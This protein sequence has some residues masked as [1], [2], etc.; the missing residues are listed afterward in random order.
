MQ[1]QHFKWFCWFC[2]CVGVLALGTALVLGT[3]DACAGVSSSC[4]HTYTCEST[5]G[6]GYRTCQNGC[7]Y[8]VE[9]SS[10][11]Y[12]TCTLSYERCVRTCQAF[13]GD[14]GVEGR[15]SPVQPPVSGVRP[16]KALESPPPEHPVSPIGGGPL[17]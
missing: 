15:P 10:K 4:A 14:V 9:T 2:A 17:R 6:D 12:D 7:P 1:W 5:C 8:K 16:T 3:K 11:C 13:E